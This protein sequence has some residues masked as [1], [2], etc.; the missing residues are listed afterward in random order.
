MTLPVKTSVVFTEQEAF[1]CVRVGQSN[2]KPG[3]K[4]EG[5]LTPLLQPRDPSFANHDLTKIILVHSDHFLILKFMNIFLKFYFISTCLEYMKSALISGRR[6]RYAAY[7]GS[8][9]FHLKYTV[10]HFHHVKLGYLDK[11]KKDKNF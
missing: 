11:S 4:A 10:I 8:F 9:L 2:H 3:G 5:K 6:C 1:E 7:L